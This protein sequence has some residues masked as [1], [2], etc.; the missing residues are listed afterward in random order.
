MTTE[1]TTLVELQEE[2]LDELYGV[3]TRLIRIYQEMQS[4]MARDK[5]TADTAR[6]DYDLLAGIEALDPLAVLTKLVNLNKGER[7]F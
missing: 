4:Q 7:L 5:Y 6:E 2:L 3:L 1:Q